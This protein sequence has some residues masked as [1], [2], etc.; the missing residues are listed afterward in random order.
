MNGKTDE[1]M[2]PKTKKAKTK[3]K[4]ARPAS[5]QPDVEGLH[6]WSVGCGMAHYWITTRSYSF[7]EAIRKARRFAK[8]T[9]ETKP[10]R[11]VKYRGTLDC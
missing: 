2:K 3:L 7:D 1:P 11:K 9:G 5:S 4:L 10:I 6:L 8:S